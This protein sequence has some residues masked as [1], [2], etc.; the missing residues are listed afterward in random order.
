MADLD[1]TFGIDEYGICGRLAPPGKF[2]IRGSTGYD[3]GSFGHS[4]HE[5]LPAAEEALAN[6]TAG[7]PR[8]WVYLEILDDT[9]QV[10][11]TRGL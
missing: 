3:N 8:D 1:V 6:E 10:L 11:K 9:G 4:D 5:N 7:S 2:R